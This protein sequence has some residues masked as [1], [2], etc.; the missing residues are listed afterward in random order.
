[1]TVN[2][3]RLDLFIGGAWTSVPIM[4][5]QV[6]ISRGMD[7][8]GSWPKPSR[9]E[10]TLDNDTYDYD[11]SS[12]TSLL[13][14]VAGRNTRVRIAPDNTPRI[15]AE[16]SEWTPE[17]S[18]EHKPGQR[19][20][21]STTSL[22]AEGLLRRLGKWTDPLRSP[23]YR[24]IS[25]RS[26]SL[27]HWSFEEDSTALLVANSRPGG[28][29]AT[30]SGSY[31][32]GDSETPLGA[33][34]SIKLT[35][36]T[37]LAGKF[38]N[39]STTAGWQVSFSFR[40]PA[41]PGSATGQNLFRWRTSNGYTWVVQVKNTGYNFIV[42]DDDDV[43]LSTGGTTFGAGREP[44]QWVTMRI[45]ASV[46]AGTVTMEPAWYAQGD[47]NEAGTTYT[48][49]G[50]VGALRTWNTDPGTYTADGWMS[51]IFGVTTTADNLVGST[52]QRVF[53]GYSGE[54]TGQRFLRLTAELGI[55][56]YIIGAS[57]DSTLMG[58]QRPDTLLNLL[59][60]IRETEDGRIDDERADIALTMRTRR[61]L[62]NQTP[63][64]A[65]T[66]PGHI[67]PPFR[68]ILDDAATHNRVTVANRLGG[69]VTV[70]QT[71][72]PMSVS[73]PPSG[74][75]EYKYTVDVNVASAETQLYDIGTHHLA[76]G[77]LERPRYDS[78]TV[79]LVANPSLKAAAIGVREGDTITITGAEPDL[80][81]LYVVGIQERVT[82]GTWTITYQVEPGEIY[83]IGIWDNPSFVWDARTSTLN[84]GYSAGA[85]VMVFTTPDANDIWST[86][87]TG[88]LMVA[89]ERI[90][91]T[92]MGAASGAGP[93]TQTATVQRA[94]NGVSKAQLAG[95]PVHLADPKRW[96]L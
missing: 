59:A 42:T 69:E 31:S 43:V 41:L 22:A 17:R 82:P 66:Y 14:G 5:D 71:T 53:N 70:S 38:A 55:T 45:K 9:I 78:V 3:V 92:T 54:T 91:V 89:G 96:G 1:M 83:D 76:K 32:L 12:P 39:A 10:C 24:T 64:L 57:A 47:S 74:V 77:T 65:L 23:M 67:S 49:S 36:S 61:S 80:I 95:A 29:P 86:A 88:D 81:R 30:L 15:W 75:G 40:L 72:G 35:D 56:R 21:W 20:G 44:T 58:P 19:K 94:R 79:D 52:A 62:Y 6:S 26:T 25:G 8:F 90:K 4:A 37:T 93:F 2:N 13:Y 7:P 33:A 50:T 51:H 16:A 46:S 48:F 60:E 63:A 84:A 27:G 11:P 73:P 18:I 28:E 85:T 34:S 87:F 68:R